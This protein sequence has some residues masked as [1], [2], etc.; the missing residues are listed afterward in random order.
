MAEH[1]DHWPELLLI[2]DTHS[3]RWDVVVRC[4]ECG[5]RHTFR[6]TEREIGDAVE[7]WHYDHRRDA[8]AD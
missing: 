8:H 3:A 4:P 2:Y 5:M 7:T 6:G 1:T